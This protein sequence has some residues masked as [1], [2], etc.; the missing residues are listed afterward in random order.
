M[1]RRR[2][3]NG[4]I[5]NNGFPSPGNFGINL[6]ELVESMEAHVCFND[7]DDLSRIAAMGIYFGLSLGLKQNADGVD[8]QAPYLEHDY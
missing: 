2:G 4:D 1:R 5:H 6:P 8:L 7:M 3:E